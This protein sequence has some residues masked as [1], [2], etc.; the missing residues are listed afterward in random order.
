MSSNSDEL[1][2]LLIILL[3]CFV[4]LIFVLGMVYLILKLKDSKKTKEKVEKADD[5][6]KAEP[7]LDK[8][9]IYKFMEFE[10]IEDNMIVIK[11]NYKYVMVVECQGINYDLMS[12]PEKVA[13]EEG[14]IQFLNTLRHPIQICVQTRTV[15]LDDSIQTYKARIKDAQ[16]DMMREQR[17]YEEMLD[18]NRYTKRQIDQEYYELTK[19]R[20]LY[21]YGNDIVSNTERMSKNNNILRKH[22]YIV[23]PYYPTEIGHNDFDKDEI[24]NIAFSSLYTRAQSLIQTLSVCNVNGK[25]LN[26]T[27]LVDLLYSAYNRDQSEIYGMDKIRKAR[28]QDSLYSTGADVLE[29]KMKQ[30]DKEIEEKAFEKATEEVQKVRYAKEDEYENLERSIEALIAES[31][32][33]IIEENQKVVGEDIAQEA[34]QNIDEEQEQKEKGEGKVEK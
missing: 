17:K 25:I 14:F 6:Y 26:S 5:S 24:Q 21:E 27:E 19:K 33:R 8:Q 22:Y 18:S 23:I 28:L 29:K 32:K 15:N 4:V 2:T 31:A 7:E 9:S 1:T 10:K 12:A 34:I 30:L 20:N 13:V 11:S 3:I 16:Q